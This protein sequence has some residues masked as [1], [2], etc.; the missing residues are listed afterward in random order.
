M[1]NE[2]EVR[3]MGEGLKY[4]KTDQYSKVTLKTIKKTAMEG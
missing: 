3:N 2:R 1:G 4:G